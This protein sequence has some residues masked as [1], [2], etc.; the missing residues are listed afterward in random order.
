[1]A[2]DQ[3]HCTKRYKHNQ[4]LNLTIYEEFFLPIIER[5]DSC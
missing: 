2:S 3:K 1:M 5:I 4:Y